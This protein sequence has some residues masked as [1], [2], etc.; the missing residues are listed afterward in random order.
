MFVP[1]YR[2]EY[3]FSY[4]AQVRLPPEVIGLQRRGARGGVPGTAVRRRLSG[5]QGPRGPP[6][7]AV[8][9]KRWLCSAVSTRSRAHVRSQRL[10]RHADKG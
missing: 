4:T 2:P 9:Q 3:I 6:A 10:P 7:V 1:D 5:L 8:G